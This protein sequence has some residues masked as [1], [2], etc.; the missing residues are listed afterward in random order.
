VQ[1]AVQPQTRQAR[2]QARGATGVTKEGGVS[3]Q[4]QWHWRDRPGVA[5]QSRAEQSRWGGYELQV[6]LATEQQVHAQQATQ[7]TGC[8]SLP[9]GLQGIFAHVANH[10]AMVV[11]TWP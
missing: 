9:C 10:S 3:K 6:Q 7:T 8:R 4:L 1:Q 11:Q 2:H 5:E